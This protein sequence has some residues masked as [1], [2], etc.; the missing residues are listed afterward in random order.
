MSIKTDFFKGTELEINDL[1]NDEYEIIRK[2]FEMKPGEKFQDYFW[3][4]SYGPMLKENNTRLLES[5]EIEIVSDKFFVSG[6]YDKN[7]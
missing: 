6:K 5:P 1:L 2:R 4:D 7:I 3:H